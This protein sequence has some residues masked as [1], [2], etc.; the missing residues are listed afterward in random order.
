MWKAR[1]TVTMVPGPGEG[2]VEGWP[3]L[4]GMLVAV[5]IEIITAMEYHQ[6][7]KQ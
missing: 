7:Q 2:S 1:S 4:A 5:V 6:P 3:G